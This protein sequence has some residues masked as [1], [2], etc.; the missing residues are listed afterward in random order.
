MK[1]ILNSLC[2][3]Y[4]IN[5]LTIIFI[6]LNS[7]NFLPNFYSSLILSIKNNIIPQMNEKKHNPALKKSGHI[8]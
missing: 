3:R 2:F 6:I 4:L 7:I 1:T 8:I 5:L